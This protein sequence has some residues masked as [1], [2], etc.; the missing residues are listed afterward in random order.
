MRLRAAWLLRTVA[1]AI[2][3]GAFLVA[4]RL[5][6]LPEIDPADELRMRAALLLARDLLEGGLHER[7]N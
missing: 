6:P 7:E 2:M 5:D 4:D 3:E 1:L